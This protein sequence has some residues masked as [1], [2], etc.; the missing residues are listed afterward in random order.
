MIMA[1]K[2]HTETACGKKTNIVFRNIYA[3]G[4]HIDILSLPETFKPGI[5][6][7]ALSFPVF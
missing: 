7:S 1:E 5:F 3:A 2:F 4:P 6:G